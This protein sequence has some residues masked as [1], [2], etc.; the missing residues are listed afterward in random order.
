MI[1]GISDAL[2]GTPYHLVVLPNF[3]PDGMDDEVR[4]IVRN[5]LADG[6][7]MS[8]AEPND[9]RVRY[10]LEAD[11]PFVIHGRTELATPHP[12]VDFDNCEFARMS[13]QQLVDA[14]AQKLAILLPPR[15]FTFGQPF[16][17]RVYA[18]RARNPEFPMKS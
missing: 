3:D 11:F 9:P 17:A 5:D 6:I 13:A 7:L 18:N 10:L 8:R 15:Q 1:R 4:R 2:K 16:A 12:Y 14:G